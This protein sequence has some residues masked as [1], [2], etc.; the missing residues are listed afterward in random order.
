MSFGVR[1][2]RA[3]GIDQE[4]LGLDAGL[5][6][7]AL[8]GGV[9]DH[10]LEHDARRLGDG[11]VLHDAIGRDPGHIL[12]PG[13]LHH[14]GGIR[15][16]E[17]VRMGRGHVEPGREARKPAPSLLHVGDGG[18][19]DQLGALGAEQVRVGD[20]E[21][22]DALAPSRGWPGPGQTVCSVSVG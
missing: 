22:A 20:H 6:V 8:L 5:D 10:R 2:R 15:H 19:R 14:G 13:Q 1:D 21:V 17:Q 7:E 18:G 3:V 11:L 16:G 9:R 12:A 4:E